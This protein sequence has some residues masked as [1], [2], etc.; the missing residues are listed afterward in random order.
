MARLPR[1]SC[2][3]RRALTSQPTRAGSPLTAGVGA[4]MAHG[5]QLLVPASPHAPLIP[6]CID[7]AGPTFLRCLCHRSRIPTPLSHSV[8]GRPSY[9]AACVTAAARPSPHRLPPW[10]SDRPAR[11]APRGVT[12]RNRPDDPEGSNS[13]AGGPAGSARKRP[14]RAGPGLPPAA[15]AVGATRTRTPPLAVMGPRPITSR[16]P[17]TSQAD[18]EV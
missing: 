2:P 15:P 7:A 8:D 11:A 4:E 3:C 6:R 12:V 16:G 17:I 5:H 1:L 10:P 18:H 9:C 13:P 14:G